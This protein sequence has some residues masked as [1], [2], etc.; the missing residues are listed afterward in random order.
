MNTSGAIKTRYGHQEQ[1]SLLL[2]T[3][4]EAYSLKNKIINYIYLFYQL[5][6]KNDIHF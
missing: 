4:I 6:L 1:Y 3:E 2:R 5:L